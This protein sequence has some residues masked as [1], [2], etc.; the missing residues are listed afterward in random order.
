MNTNNKIPPL[1]LH[2]KRER[3]KK[4]GKENVRCLR[5]SSFGAALKKGKEK[6]W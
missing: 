1:Q 4:K 3:E 6:K 5:I 2:F